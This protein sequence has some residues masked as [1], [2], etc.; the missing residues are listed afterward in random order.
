MVQK[1]LVEVL[2][3]CDYPDMLLDD[4]PRLPRD[5]E[6]DCHASNLKAPCLMAPSDLKE[7]N[8]QL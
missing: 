4:L 8:E 6:I 3:V 2:V 7:F 1:D 5:K